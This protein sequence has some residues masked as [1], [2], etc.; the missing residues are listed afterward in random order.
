M[1]ELEFLLSVLGTINIFAIF[2]ISIEID[3]YPVKFNFTNASVKTLCILFFLLPAVLLAKFLHA[4]FWS[5][6]PFKKCRFQVG[7]RVKVTIFGEQRLAVITKNEKICEGDKV[8]I[9]FD[10]EPYLHDFDAKDV[11]KIS[12][13]ESALK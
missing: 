7:D 4:K 10:N 9:R 2:F 11:R 1:K 8:E 12:K 13:L 6:K 5:A 3:E